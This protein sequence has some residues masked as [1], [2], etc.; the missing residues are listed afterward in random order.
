MTI[1]TF[2]GDVTNALTHFTLYGMA[3][4]WESETGKR[5]RLWW[6]RTR[7]PQPQ[8]DIGEAQFDDVAAA[9]HRHA[10][11]HSTDDS[12]V[13]HRFTHEGRA[14]GTFS[15]RIKT[16]SSPESWRH[17]QA[18]RHL[19]IDQ[20][21]QPSTDDLRLIAALGEPAYWRFEQNAPRPD[22]GASRWEMKTRNRGEEFVG[23]RLG[24]LAHAVTARTGT[25][26]LSGLRGDTLVDENGS[27]KADSRTATGLTRPGPVDNAVAWCAL[28]GLSQLPTIHQTDRQSVTP[29]ATVPARRTHPVSMHLPVPTEPLTTA[30]L[31]SLL[32]SKQLASAVE[33]NDSGHTAARMWLYNRGV[34]A[35]AQFPVSVSDNPSAPERQILAGTLTTLT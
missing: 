2:P 17:L 20:L 12:W 14:T 4:I 35:I 9:V 8:L 28:W 7:T 10:T 26:I 27:S 19:T 11:Q 16:P 21:E 31:R 15:P 33:P 25:Q 3:A 6:S 29:G 1:L 32:I 22:D 13:Q 23:N 34:P 18:A 24:P 5:T 30:R